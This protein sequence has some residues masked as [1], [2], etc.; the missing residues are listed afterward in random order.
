MFER[1]RLTVQ[2]VIGRKTDKMDSANQ[3]YSLP[4]AHGVIDGGPIRNLV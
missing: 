2:E 1:I 3:D 4:E